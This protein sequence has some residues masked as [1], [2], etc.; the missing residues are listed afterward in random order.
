MIGPGTGI[1]VYLACGHTDMMG[2]TPPL[3]QRQTAGLETR[4]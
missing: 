1:R 2:W 4:E 3:A